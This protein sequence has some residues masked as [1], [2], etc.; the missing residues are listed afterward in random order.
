M[1]ETLL[2]V[3]PCNKPW[4]RGGLMRAE[5]LGLSPS[6]VHAAGAALQQ[7]LASWELSHP[8]SAPQSK[9]RLGLRVQRAQLPSEAGQE[10]ARRER[11][12][13]GLRRQQ[14]RRRRRGCRRA[15]GRAAGG[16]RGGPREAVGRRRAAARAMAGRAVPGLLPWLLGALGGLVA[17][18]EVPSPGSPA[19]QVEVTLR[20]GAEPVRGCTLQGALL[21][22][23]GLELQ[24]AAAAAVRGSLVLVNDTD[25]RLEDDDPW[26][27]V[28][29]VEGEQAEVPKHHKE[30][31]FARA[32]VNKMKRALVLGA[33]ALLILALNQNTIRELDV[34]QVLSKPVVIVQ[35][36]ENV[37][38][39]LGALLRGLQ[40]TAKITYQAGLLENMGLTLTLWSTCGLS[41]GG[42]YA[43]WQGVICTGENSSKVQKYL[44]QL[45]N[46][47]LLIALILC[48]GVIVQAQRH[49]RHSQLDQESEL[50]LKQHIAQKLLALKTRRYHPGRSPHSWAHE[51]DSCAICL[52][53]FQKNQC[54]RVLPCLHEFHQDCVD[55]WLLLQ[56]TCPLCKHNILGNC[57]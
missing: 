37:T 32:V 52:D 53:Q 18:A 20:G 4:L 42:V 57:C 26:I 54:L 11:G 25:P 24:P 23:A 51:I 48:T 34:S 12:Q 33:S 30:E 56:Q 15:G 17:A 8:A 38:K 29:P 19:A 10:A 22:R 13:P 45:W 16:W 28:V 40:A 27:G 35:T 9:P 47:I 21:G 41:R 5:S 2:C 44:Q 55:P 49:S 1:V 31:S 6:S 39:L 14:M 46:A 3:H 7:T 36:S 50:D 43:E